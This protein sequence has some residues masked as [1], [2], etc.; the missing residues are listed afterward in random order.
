MPPKSTSF[1]E[2]WLVCLCSFNTTDLIC[3]FKPKDVTRRLG[4]NGPAGAGGWG[5]PTATAGPAA[6]SARKT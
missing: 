3:L 5:A 2:S 1:R 6:A 4:V